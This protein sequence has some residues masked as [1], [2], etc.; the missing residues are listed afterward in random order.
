MNVK[1]NPKLIV[2]IGVLCVSLTSILIKLSQAPPF[3]ML[4]YRLL[5]TIFILSGIVCFKKKEEL[6][7][8][9]RKQFQI[10]IL[11]GLVFSFHILS[12]ILAVRNTSIASAVILSDCHPIFVVI[13]GYIFLREKLPKK[14]IAGILISFIGCVL[15]SFMDLLKGGNHI[16]GD[17]FGIATAFFMAVYFIMGRVVRENLSNYIYIFLVYGWAFV[18]VTIFAIATKTPFYPYPLRE[19]LIFLGL[20]VFCTILGHG[21][22][23]WGLE[24]VKPSF[25][26]TAFLLEPIYASAIALFLFHEIPSIWQI[27]GGAIIIYGL[28]MY[29]RYEEARKITQ[30]EQVAIKS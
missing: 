13:L 6:K 17:L 20:A 18:F 15:I 9:T 1:A 16:V 28:Y 24:Y 12:W 8:L 11:V 23:N 27:V 21:L 22:I 26:S 3:A 25:A 14:A 29:N 19:Y 7:K 2:I 5:F 10:C 30:E 4:F